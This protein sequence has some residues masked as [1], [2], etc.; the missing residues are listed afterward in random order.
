[1][2]QNVRHNPKA[3]LAHKSSF[4]NRA[5]SKGNKNDA[6]ENRARSTGWGSDT[7]EKAAKDFG[8]VYPSPIVE[9]SSL[10]V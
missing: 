1:M 6:S 8:K 7:T 5:G 3:R 9:Q 10:E 4:E 2:V